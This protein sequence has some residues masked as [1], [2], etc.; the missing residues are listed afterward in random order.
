MPR[1]RSRSLESRMQSPDELAGAELAALPQQ[2]ID[3]RGLA[4]V[5]VGDD[6]DVTDI[7]ATHSLAV[8]RCQWSVVS[9]SKRHRAGNRTTAA[10]V[11]GELRMSIPR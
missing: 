11:A 2:G 1:S 9:K 6:G 8:V 10:T 3:Q 5:D 4:V 7:V